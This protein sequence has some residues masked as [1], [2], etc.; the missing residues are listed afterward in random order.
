MKT[1]MKTSDLKTAKELEQFLLG[2]QYVAFAVL[3]NKTER[4][5]FSPYYASFIRATVLAFAS[6]FIT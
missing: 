4:F 5:N 1:I 6:H 3:G 2:N